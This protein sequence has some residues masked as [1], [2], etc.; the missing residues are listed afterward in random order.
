[1]IVNAYKTKKILPK[2]NLEVILNESL[3]TLSENSVVIVSAKIVAL[4]EGR[5]IKN[6]GTV[7]K[8]DLVKKESEFYHNDKKYFVDNAPLLTI[9]NHIVVP[10]AGIDES[11]GNG[12]FVLWPQ[13]IMNSTKKIWEYLRT[14]HKLTNLGVIL[15]D[16]YFLPLRRGAIGVGIGWCG[17]IPVDNHIGTPDVFGKMLKYTTSSHIDGLSAAAEVVMG[18]ADEQTPLAVITNIPFVNFVDR[19]PTKEEI[20]FMK[21][22]KEDD[23]FA[24]LLTAVTWKKHN[25]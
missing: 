18:E 6:D 7:K 17:F 2:D 13:D 1:M 11:N 3:P 5:V 20:A 12:Y 15:T 8:E 19:P 22:V 24:P 21:I 4:C 25:E 16:S 10:F 14:K 23:S 9:K